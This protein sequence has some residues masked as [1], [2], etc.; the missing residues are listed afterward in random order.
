MEKQQQPKSKCYKFNDKLV[1][2]AD[3]YLLNWN[4]IWMLLIFFTVCSMST[5]H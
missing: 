3:N 5:V 1:L 4:E 2:R